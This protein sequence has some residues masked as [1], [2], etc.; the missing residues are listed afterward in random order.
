MLTIDP[1]V[2]VRG[3]MIMDD[4]VHFCDVSN[5]GEGAQARAA[6]IV[7]AVNLHDD[8][9]KALRPFYEYVKRPTQPIHAVI[10]AEEWERVIETMKKVDQ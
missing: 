2:S 1:R 10:R 4:G 8:L 6:K 7:K 3:V 9:V 5:G